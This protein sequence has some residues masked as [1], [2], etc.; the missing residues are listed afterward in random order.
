LVLQGRKRIK[1][2]KYLEYIL[3]HVDE[4]VLLKEKIKGINKK[5]RAQ[6]RNREKSYHGTKTKLRLPDK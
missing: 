5:M 3:P 2:H 4:I 1:I 6:Q